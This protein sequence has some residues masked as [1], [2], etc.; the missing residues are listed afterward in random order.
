MSRRC[1][2]CLLI[3]L[4]IACAHRLEDHI[5]GGMATQ[6]ESAWRAWILANGYQAK[7]LYVVLLK[8]DVSMDPVRS[9]GF[10][11]IIEAWRVVK[12]YKGN[13][14]DRD[15][16]DLVY[17]YSSLGSPPMGPQLPGRRLHHG[18]MTLAV[19][20]K[21]RPEFANDKVL[22][23]RQSMYDRGDFILYADAYWMEMQDPAKR[24]PAE[25]RLVEMEN[26]RRRESLSGWDRFA[27]LREAWCRGGSPEYPAA[28][29]DAEGCLA[30]MV[31]QETS[32]PQM[33]T[34]FGRYLVPCLEKVK[35]GKAI[36]RVNDF[37]V[38][39]TGPPELPR[40]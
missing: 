39:K 24:K 31:K 28:L 23:F 8:R 7:D 26:K 40:P 13:L 33:D 6:Q 21:I 10:C 16:V 25:D 22:P 4:P 36:P 32:F 12:D 1:I 17:F 27:F 30:A 37:V 5:P 38:R 14:Q 35:E 3:L 19:I 20:G 15:G 29:R 34:D 18:G 2:L 9:A 11:S